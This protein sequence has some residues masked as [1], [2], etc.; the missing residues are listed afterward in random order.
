MN[1][2]RLE[3]KIRTRPAKPSLVPVE[4]IPCYINNRDRVS[5]VR[6]TV[7]WLLSAGTR[8]VVILDNDSTYPPL[9][10]YYKVLPFGVSVAFLGVNAGPWAFWDRG[11][12][13]QQRT[14]YVVTDSDLVPDEECPKDLISKLQVLLHNRP[15]S[16]KV[17]PGLKIDDVPQF[18]GLTAK[19]GCGMPEQLDYWTKRYNSEAFLAAIDTTFALYGAGSNGKVGQWFDDPN[20]LRMDKPYLFRHIPWYFTPPITDEEEIYYRTHCKQG[21][22]HSYGL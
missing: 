10:E 4:E 5:T 3:Q 6:T 18:D 21:W 9:L 8:R 20:N 13:L 16:G 1:R 11:M 12:H 2:I 17:G 19:N 15:E 7:D 14:P 22:S